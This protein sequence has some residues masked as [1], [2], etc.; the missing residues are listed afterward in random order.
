MSNLISTAAEYLHTVVDV[1]VAGP[2]SV[3]GFPVILRGCWVNADT[4]GG[5]VTITNNDVVVY[6]IPVSTVAGQWLEFGDVTLTTDCEV[7]TSAASG[8]SITVVYKP[9]QQ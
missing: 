8:G 2:V 6:T 3:Y 9:I 1:S 7:V 5:S 4:E